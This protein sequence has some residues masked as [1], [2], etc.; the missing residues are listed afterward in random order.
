VV[1]DSRLNF[2]SPLDEYRLS[3]P[4]GE[5]L[6]VR[7]SRIRA[8]QTREP[9]DRLTKVKHAE[10]CRDDV[11]RSEIFLANVDSRFDAN[12]GEVCVKPPFRPRSA[13]LV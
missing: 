9:S 5:N 8:I 12:P 2:R 4:R 11:V 1:D 13:D 7:R 6:A 10:I 3:K